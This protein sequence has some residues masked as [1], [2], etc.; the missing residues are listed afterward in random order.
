MS[1]AFFEKREGTVIK[2]ETFNV[3]PQANEFQAK[4]LPYLE[5]PANLKGAGHTTVQLIKQLMKLGY[6]NSKPD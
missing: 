2:K 1:R 4:G 5:P 3:N 6:F